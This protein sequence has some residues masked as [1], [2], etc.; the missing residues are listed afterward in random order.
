MHATF[1]EYCYLHQGSQR[2][3]NAR[4]HSYAHNNH[5]CTRHMHKTEHVYNDLRNK[6]TKQMQPLSDQRNMFTP[7]KTSYITHH[8]QIKT[9]ERDHNTFKQKGKN[10]S[11]KRNNTEIDLAIKK[12]REILRQK[13]RSLLNITTNITSL[14][15]PNTNDNIHC[16]Q[17]CYC[18]CRE[19]IGRAHV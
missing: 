8:Q 5:P 18:L 13:H 3:D 16:L 7:S 11:L 15:C 2:T 14:I 4:M 12:L 6:D 10:T 19:Q 1:H 9:R 17:H